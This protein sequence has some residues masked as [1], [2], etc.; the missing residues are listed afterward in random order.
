[1]H[2]TLIFFLVISINI[3][4]NT[5]LDATSLSKDLYPEII[6]NGNYEN[7]I[8][9]PSQFLN[10]SYG[11]RVASPE[12]VTNALNKWSKQSNKLKVVE[13]AKTH[14]GRPLHAVFISSPE[15]LNN[16]DNIKNKI[17][18]LSDARNTS[19]RE[20]TQIIKSL[21]AVAWMAYSI[22]GNETSGGDAA[23]GLIY[24]LIANQ[25]KDI[26]N[27]LDEMIIIIDPLMN[28]D[29]RARFAKNLE[30][31]RGTAPN[32]DD[33]S[34]LHTG[35]W[36]YGRTN[37]YY[38]DLNRDWLYLTQ[39][40][41]QG[42]VALIN[43]WRP[44]ILVDGHEMGS[45]DTFMTGPPREPI[46]KN[47]D[48]DLIKWGNV[49]AQD[50]ASAFDDNNWRFYTGEWH[51]DLYPGYSFYVQ[52]RGTLGILYEQSRMAEDGVKRP[53]GTIQSYKESVHHQ[54]VSTLANLETLLD[55]SK[56]IYQDYWDGRKYNISKDSIYADTSFVVLP[57]NNK[58]RLNTLATKLKA[59]DIEIYQNDKP[60][61]SSNV[62]RQNG[63]IEKDFVI[64]VGSMIIPNRQP[65]APLISAIL[66]FDADINESVLLKERQ[67]R[68]RNGSS[69]MYDTTA[70]NFT[71]MYGL[72]AITVPVNISSNLKPWAPSSVT[73][74]VT[75]DAVMW[76]VDGDD[77]RSVAFAARLMEQDVQVRVIDKQS[78]L[79][80]HNLSRGSITVIKMDNPQYK[81]LLTVVRKAAEDL[82]ISIVSIE[83]GFG[84]EDLPD[85]GGRH[86]K[87]LNKPQIAILSHEGFNSYDVGTSW[88]SLDHH[89]GIRHS[90]LN[91]S[92]ISYGDLR[93]YNTIIFPSG[94]PDINNYSKEILINWVKQGGTLIA[95]N[96]S[97]RLLAS[98]NEFGDVKLLQQTFEDTKS[99]NID[100]MR[101]I[102]SL[103]NNL[104]K[105]DV[106][107]NRVNFEI[108]YPWE[109]SDKTYSK[110]QLEMRDKWQS[111]LMPSGSM[112]SA[113][114]DQQHWLTFGTE[115][116]IPI[117]YA[118]NPIL[119]T[120]GSSEAP[121]RI[122]ELIKNDDVEESRMINWSQ[123]PK[124]YDL[125]VRMS[126]LVWPEASQR[127]ANS[128]YLTREKIGKGQIILFSGEPNF[129]GS[130]R[131]TNRLWLNAV[132]Y[133]SGLGTDTLVTQ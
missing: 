79:S 26:L 17:S 89:L 67:K 18:E 105:N 84:A 99:Y 7:N 93:R 23:L 70:F 10:F 131:G 22:H 40:E 80:N 73:Y 55:N 118:N 43:Q 21:P 116:L 75:E 48:R 15:N 16:L 38:F 3:H 1:M 125:N 127:I 63:D 50:Q 81:D 20:A 57:T 132:I 30:Q 46:N 122:G 104:N 102:Y 95:N 32:Y 86:F 49:F 97:T 61:N 103:D 47:I 112:V 37:H 34:L 4:S 76:A 133:G 107:S 83:S 66:E 65:E 119:M 45:Q 19:D 109:S 8:D 111:L 5:L 126:G 35:D 129:R 77:D 123:V 115:D 101:E 2:K 12:Q 51:E 128:A 27:M 58:G 113:R 130:A 85:W 114:S 98:D 53:E 11:D 90:Q 68:L 54:F 6:L 94:T 31:Y 28:P 52:F 36:P 13:Y 14:E 25:D 78:I 60:I 29:G 106:N 69:V 74:D 39:P 87:L 41:T 92:L 42:R 91:S 56:S 62:L 33:Q 71:M 120:G 24:H 110:D 44:Q 82:G 64:P 59:Q 121:I 9:N 100:L 117:L 72:P 96:R 124:G 88:W 108:N